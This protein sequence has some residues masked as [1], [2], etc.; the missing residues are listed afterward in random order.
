MW[1]PSWAAL[2]AS[3][4]PLSSSLQTLD[5]WELVGGIRTCCWNVKG[6]MMMCQSCL[7][8]SRGNCILKTL[9]WKTWGSLNAQPHT[10]MPCSRFL[11]MAR[12]PYPAVPAR[13]RLTVPDFCAIFIIFF[14]TC[15][16]GEISS[17]F[18]PWSNALN[19]C[20]KWQTDI[21]QKLCAAVV[22][23]RWFEIGHFNTSSFSGRHG[24][25]PIFANKF[26]WGYVGV[27]NGGHPLSPEC[28][29]FLGDYIQICS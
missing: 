26:I 12:P 24:W 15:H 2:V 18:L 22:S 21:F 14:L 3:R 11:Q 10:R 25:I 23:I 9:L 27:G 6:V 5:V 28:S 16:Q 13:F 17:F 7:I 19:G 20:P 4:F 29:H 1:V 8:Y